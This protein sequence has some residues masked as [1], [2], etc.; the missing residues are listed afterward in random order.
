MQKPRI[1]VIFDVDGVLVDSGA[2]HAASWR[3]VAEQHAIHVSD[4]EFKRTFGQPSRDIIRILWGPGVDD[5]QVARLD[6]EKEAAYRRL[7]TGAVPLMPGVHEAVRALRDAGLVLAVASSGPQANV[8]LVLREGD[9]GQYF[10]AV[11][12]G[13]DV[14]RG[15]PAPDCFLLAAD[16]AGIDPRACVV[17]E[18]APVGIEAARAARMQAIGFV[19]THPAARLA[20]AGAALTVERLCD[21]TPVVI[22]GL[23]GHG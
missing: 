13:F 18:D 4:E 17:V 7:I 3:C 2:A 9:L 22:E 16:R 11:V 20:A 8:E 10:D 14:E 19:G 23:L 1:G 21:I 5:E 15:K 6:D 12:T